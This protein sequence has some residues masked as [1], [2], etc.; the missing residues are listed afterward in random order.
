MKK[1]RKPKRGDIAKRYQ[2]TEQE[3]AVVDA[4]FARTEQIPP[5]PRLK[6]M[7]SD[8]VSKIDADHPDGAVAQILLLEALGTTDAAFLDGLLCE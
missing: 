2:P 5:V 8:G 3:R 4:Y 6:V 1:R 7:K